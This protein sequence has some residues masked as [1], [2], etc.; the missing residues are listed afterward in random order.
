MKGEVKW[1]KLIKQGVG[2]LFL[3]L[4]LRKHV[5]SFNSCS[6]QNQSDNFATYLRNDLKEKHFSYFSLVY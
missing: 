3:S 6:G 5:G 4:S 2:V 1:I